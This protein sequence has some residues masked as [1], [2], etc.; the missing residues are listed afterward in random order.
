MKI[1]LDSNPSD[2]PSCYKVI[3]EDGRDMLIQTDWDYPS[4]ASIFGWDKSEVLPDK[5]TAYFNRFSIELPQACVNDCSHHGQCGDDVAF[6]ACEIERPEAITP[7]AL[8]A[9]LKE[10]GA[11][12]AE[13]L[14]DDSANWNRLIWIAAGNLK[15]ETCRHSGTDGT[16]DCPNC[17]ATASEFI[18]AARQWLDD[19]DG[20]EADDPGYFD[21]D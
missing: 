16:V 2:A 15:E 3:A 4:I 20:A 19:N 21:N 1:T 12:S 7:E 11:W 5:R 18:S 9:E 10:Y 17:G 13:E 8:A 6:W 14:Q